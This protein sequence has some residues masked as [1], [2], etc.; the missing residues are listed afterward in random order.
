MPSIVTY[1]QVAYFSVARFL[2]GFGRLLSEFDVPKPVGATESQLRKLLALQIK[3]AEPA[4]KEQVEATVVKTLDRDRDTRAYCA[5][6][7]VKN[8]NYA[9]GTW[10]LDHVCP[11]RWHVSQE[12]REPGGKA[13]Y[14]EWIT[15]GDKTFQ[16]AGMWFEMEKGFN[17]T[18]NS[19]L[20]IKYYLDML[21]SLVPKSAAIVQARFCVLTFV[22]PFDQPDNPLLQVCN[23]VRGHCELQLWINVQ[24]CQLVRVALRAEG[25]DEDGNALDTEL[26]HVFAAYNEPIVVEPPPWLNAARNEE[27]KLVVVNTE[28]AQVPH[29]E[30]DSLH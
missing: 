9:L 28:V 18:D 11:D 24:S 13:D 15:V 10:R 8:D 20:T 3:D 16:N 14:D 23:S 17:D 21:R 19:S 25:V 5:K 7:V 29:Y 4:T 2:G 30:S 26:L 12:L 6:R 22:P 27:G 1:L